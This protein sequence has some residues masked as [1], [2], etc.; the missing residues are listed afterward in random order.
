M[1]LSTPTSNHVSLR[2]NSASPSYARRPQR[3]PEPIH[4]RDSPMLTP[5]P[6][7]RRPLFP[8]NDQFDDFDGGFLHSPFKSP[9]NVQHLYSSYSA[10]PEPISADD[11]EGAIFLDSPTALRPTPTPHPQP[12]RTPKRPA[13]SVMQLNSPLKASGA[14]TKR[15]STPLA[16]TPLRRHNLTPLSIQ[17]SLDSKG[18]AFDRLAP[19]PPPKFSARTPQSKTET[20]HHLKKQT[21]TLTRLRITDFDGSGDEFDGEN[22]DS[23]C[24]MSDDD[25]EGRGNVFLSGSLSG[26]STKRGILVS[27]GKNKD[28]EVAAVSPGGHITKRRAR[29]RPVSEE[30]L[31]SVY[32][33]P[34]PEKPKPSKVPRPGPPAIPFPSNRM[35]RRNGSASSS[36]DMGSPL[37]RRRTSA[38]TC[39]PPMLSNGLH[40]ISLP[41]PGPRPLNR[42]ESATLFFGPAIPA[43]VKS[44]PG[45]TRINSTMAA[46][47]SKHQLAHKRSKAHNRHSYA[48]PQQ[49]HIWNAI[50]TDTEAPSPHSSPI[51]DV[52]NSSRDTDMEEDMFFGSDSGTESMSLRPE[53][54][55]FVFN[56]TQ[57]TPSPRMKQQ[58]QTLP[59]KYRPRDSGVVV[60][61]DDDY[62]NKHGT[63]CASLN[64]MPPASS[65]LNSINSD[66]DDGLVTPGIGPGQFSGWPDADIRINDSSTSI[67]GILATA[68]PDA[69]I[70]RI[71]AATSKGAKSRGETSADGEAKRPP[72]TPVKKVKT[73]FLNGDRP[74][75][76]AVTHK[77]A[78]LDFDYGGGFGLPSEAE[79][80][81]KKGK[82]KPRQSLPALPLEGLKQWGAKNG[83]GGSDTEDEEDSPSGRKVTSKAGLYGGLG[84]GRPAKKP[85]AEKPASAVSRTRWLMRR[86]SSGAF[87]FSSG[88]DSSRNATPTRVNPSD[89]I[90]A[91]TRVHAQDSPSKNAA[92]LSPLRSTSGSSSSSSSTLHSPSIRHLS[93]GPA[94][95]QQQPRN[96]P[97]SSLPLPT[98]TFNEPHRR[99]PRLSAGPYPSCSR[100]APRSRLSDSFAYEQ[101]GR[102]ERDFMELD[103]VG[104]GEFG[105]VIKVRRK[106]GGQDGKRYAIKQ[107]KRFEGVRHRL[108]LREEV[109]TLQHL[110]KVATFG[111]KEN[112]HPN[113]LGYVDSWEEN[114]ALY[115]QTE[116]CGMG[117]LARFLW[118]YGRV[119]PRLDEARVWKMFVDLSNGLRFVHD[120]GVIHLDIKPANIFITSEGRFKIGDFGMASFWP[121]PRSTME[122]SGGEWGS[123]ANASLRTGVHVSLGEGPFEREGDKLYL[124]P[125]VL[126]GTYGKAAD[127]FSLG[128]TMLETASNIVVPDQGDAWHQLRQ[129]DFSLVDL[130][131]SPE[132]LGLL[133]SMMRTNPESRVSAQDVFEHPVVARARRM[134]ENMM[135][136]SLRKGLG[137]FRASPLGSVDEGFLADILE[138][139]AGDAMDV[140]S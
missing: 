105:R 124:A 42:V 54:A 106:D 108:R 69:F 92:K 30:L 45:R 125:E 123:A 20:E 46:S 2:N 65:S 122:G 56:I 86:S 90:P 44:A 53:G 67:D 26:K 119:F 47:L 91:L 133:R 110:S 131:D 89:D 93:I 117:N 137:A 62:D 18:I 35:H 24:D 126:Q 130:D 138:R 129:E 3:T 76:S 10:K 87:S 25:A 77:V 81:N 39:R 6:L 104:S 51:Y 34:A 72:G 94:A 116:L 9:P 64:L 27:K 139:R 11:A 95:V 83:G 118:E 80:G 50:R 16:S 12:L 136:D 135:N 120:A 79:V 97:R 43:P 48:G 36:S 71:L 57:G 74:W 40:P 17:R 61:D 114:E 63:P 107:S 55:S 127:V 73:T 82:G 1:L 78:N 19:L 23:G 21:A 98:A 15:K 134:M 101:P 132:L 14:G 84:L 70:I 113:V 85:E 32:R 75:Q 109:D 28:E 4:C 13:L 29:S 31:E 99:A 33:S 52:G 41:R 96:K 111:S 100:L 38:A 68:D 7:R 66:T 102:Y 5:S 103:E 88:S 140:C 128:M 8:Q 112:C 115:I 121:R 59:K 49:A 22:V 60:S 58:P 37:P